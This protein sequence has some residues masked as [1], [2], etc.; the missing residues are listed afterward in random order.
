MLHGNR[1]QL[2]PLEDACTIVLLRDGHAGLEVLMLERP[3]TSRSFA[4]AWVFPGREGGRRRTAWTPD[5]SR[6]DDFA[7]AQVAGLREL[8]EE[9]GQQLSGG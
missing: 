3:A 8:A 6:L 2:A 7:A 9:T 4:G 5:G 1:A